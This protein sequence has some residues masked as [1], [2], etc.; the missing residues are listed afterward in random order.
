MLMM[1][2]KKSMVVSR[3]RQWDILAQSEYKVDTDKK[4]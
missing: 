4:A 2:F 3:K 1:V